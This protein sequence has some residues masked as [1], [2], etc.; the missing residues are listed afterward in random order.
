MK[1]HVMT[2]SRTAVPRRRRGLR[3]RVKRWYRST[4][5]TEI[6]STVGLVVVALAG[7]GVV[8]ALLLTN[9]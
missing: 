6:A 4:P 5:T 3:H 1:H 7:L 8:V 2:S 9:G